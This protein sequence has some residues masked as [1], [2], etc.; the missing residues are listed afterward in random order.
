MLSKEITSKI[1]ARKAGP[2]LAL[3]SQPPAGARTMISFS[4][5]CWVGLD[6]V[7]DKVKGS[8]HME[9]ASTHW[10]TNRQMST[11]FV[12]AQDLWRGIVG[13]PALPFP[14]FPFMR[15]ALPP[16]AR[17]IWS[18]V[19]IQNPLTGKKKERTEKDVDELR[20]SSFRVVVVHPRRLVMGWAAMETGVRYWRLPSSGRIF[21]VE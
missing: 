20:T 1:V 21:G 3:S 16:T 11:E 8:P 9:A 17:Y 18:F 12:F 10:P 6:T 13:G 14:S 19:A 7:C 2:E 15:V 4:I 5:F